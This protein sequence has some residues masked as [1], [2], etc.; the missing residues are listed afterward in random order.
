MIL[1]GELQLYVQRQMEAVVAAFSKYAACSQISYSEQLPVW[2]V[3]GKEI[4]ESY[5]SLR[6]EYKQEF[7]KISEIIDDRLCIEELNQSDVEELSSDSED[8]K[9][10]KTVKV[11]DVEK[12]DDLHSESESVPEV[13]SSESDDSDDLDNVSDSDEESDL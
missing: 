2:E 11:V 13:D 1:N 8:E 4:L 7:E 10:A 5:E 3:L 9:P 6:E 12:D